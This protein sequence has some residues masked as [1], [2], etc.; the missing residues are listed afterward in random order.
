MEICGTEINLN[1]L[2]SAYLNCDCMEGMKRFPDKY[3]EVAIVDPQYG[4]NAPNMAMGTN[5]SRTKGGS[6]ERS[7]RQGM[8]GTENQRSTSDYGKL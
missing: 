1:N 4:I 3:F 7:T 8:K 6:E 2:Q 5:R